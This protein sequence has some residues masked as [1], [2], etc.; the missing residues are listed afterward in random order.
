LRGRRVLEAC[1]GGWLKRDPEGIDGS[2]F[3]RDLYIGKKG[4]LIEMG[5][6][7]TIVN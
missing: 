3:N 5:G 7:K 4:K 1:S 6:R 2:F